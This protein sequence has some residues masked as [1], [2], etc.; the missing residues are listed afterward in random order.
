MR[1]E[2]MLRQIHEEKEKLLKQ[3]EMIRSRQQDRLKQVRLKLQF[4]FQPVEKYFDC[5]G[6]VREGSA[7][8]T[9]AD[10]QAEGGAADPGEEK[11]GEAEGGGSDSAETGRGDQEAARGDRR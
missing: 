9:G 2:E 6:E 10:A 11:A 5:S 8:E 4:E 1:Q 7:R 3:E